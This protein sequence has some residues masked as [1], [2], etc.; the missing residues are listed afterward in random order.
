MRDEKG[1]KLER[2]SNL[3]RRLCSRFT[4]RRWPKKQITYGV[5]GV[6]AVL[7][8]LPFPAA[9]LF[10]VGDVV[11]DPTSYATLAKIWS[12]DVST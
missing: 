1:N 12:S 7:F 10:G 11:F 5:A 2:L 8:L 6:A 9:G 3:S 4:T